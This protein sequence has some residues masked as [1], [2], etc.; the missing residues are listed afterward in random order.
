MLAEDSILSHLTPGM[1][2]STSLLQIKPTCFAFTQVDLSFPH[3]MAP[4]KYSPQLGA[5]M[6]SVSFP[7]LPI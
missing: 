1:L 3:L 2:S 7:F 6:I 5:P 4:M